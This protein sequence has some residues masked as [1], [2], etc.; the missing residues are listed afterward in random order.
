MR[1]TLTF[2]ERIIE[3]FDKLS[4]EEL[5]RVL[6]R[7]A[8]EYE[9]NSLILD[10]IY[11]AIVALDLSG[12]IIA[13]NK[14]ALRLL[15]MKNPSKSDD[16]RAVIKN[17]L[18]REAIDKSLVLGKN[19]ESL[20]VGDEE[21]DRLLSLSVLSLARG[22]VMK[23]TL[24]LAKD[25]TLEKKREEQLKRAEHLAALTTLAAGVAH[26]I[27][28]P[29]GSL[30]IHIQLIDRVCKSLNGNEKAVSEIKEF[31]SIMKEEVGRLE[32]T[33]NSFLFSVKKIQL[34]KRPVNIKN[35][36]TST[37]NFLKYEIENSG[38]EVSVSFG[39]ELP[40]IDLDEH[41]IK[42]CIINIIQNSIDAISN[43]NKKTIEINAYLD[44]DK[45]NMII[46]EI[47]SGKGMP[48]EML[49]KAF[50]PYFTTKKSGTGLGL[51]NVYRIIDAHGGQIKINSVEGKGTEVKLSI[52]VSQ[53][54]VKLLKGGEN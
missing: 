15:S 10:N 35:L 30:D 50:E 36:I 42:Q 45:R 51:T 19:V 48:K 17:E 20:L 34:N 8:G 54:T 3:R 24:L 7:L 14:S 21:N 46:S 9:I 28:N 12:N 25:V 23:G 13:Y 38:A 2:L 11:E 18:L 4:E 33:V 22:G 41:Y 1:N 27:K 52:P 6:S 37:L 44:E 49:N 29:L 31:I 16:I 53:R 32:E 26:E 47:D 40:N 5:S 39:D 43:S